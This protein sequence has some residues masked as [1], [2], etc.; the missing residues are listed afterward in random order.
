MTDDSLFFFCSLHYHIIT[1]LIQALQTMTLHLSEY[2][3]NCIVQS[4]FYQN[5]LTSDISLPQSTTDDEF[6]LQVVPPS[7][8]VHER[9]TPLLSPDKLSTHMK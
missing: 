9:G 6:S 2:P 4:L 3:S 1:G 5:N 8:G 7:G